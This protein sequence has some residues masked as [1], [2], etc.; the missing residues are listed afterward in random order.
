MFSWNRL[1]TQENHVPMELLRELVRR[2]LPCTLTSEADIDRLRVLRAAGYI[3]AML[4]RP[5]SG[6]E[7]GR[8][9]AI[10]AQG[11]EL[12]AQLQENASA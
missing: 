7:L 6:S 8:V 2:P 11:R 10:T 5:G 3:V 12:L 9:L 1:N 4:P